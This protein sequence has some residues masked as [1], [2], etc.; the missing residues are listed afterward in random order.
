M[1][2]GA[3]NMTVDI[4]SLNNASFNE[5]NSSLLLQIGDGLTQNGSTYVASPNGIG[6]ATYDNWIGVLGNPA[7]S[8]IVAYNTTVSN[9]GLGV[10]EYTF[11]QAD[12]TANPASG[13]IGAEVVAWNST[14]V[15]LEQLTGYVP[16]P[17]PTI[18]PDGNF[19]ILAA[20]SVNLAVLDAT[21]NFVGEQA[22]SSELTFGT[23]GPFP[24]F[25]VPEPGTVFLMPV[26]VIGLMLARIPAVR[27]FLGAR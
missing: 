13:G 3:N 27:S 4:A 24:S 14:G 1:R 23:T 16:G 10:V 20:P 12:G 11:T 18:T 5:L 26:M 17:N 9:S 22:T 6:L 25:A 2:N 15:L 21:G 8:D 7:P 19:L